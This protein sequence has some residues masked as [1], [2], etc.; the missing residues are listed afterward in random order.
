M[1]SGVLPPLFLH[2]LLLMRRTATYALEGIH[3]FFFFLLLGDAAARR[4]ARR[5][6]RQASP[7]LS[8]C[9]RLVPSFAP[10]PWRDYTCIAI[11]FHFSLHG[12]CGLMTLPAF[13]Y[14]YAPPARLGRGHCRVPSILSYLVVGMAGGGL[15]HLVAQCSGWLAPTCSILAVRRH[16][17]C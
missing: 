13:F 2:S 10:L 15:W 8:V 12:C 3:F 4:L 6:G 16:R 9:V 1:R 7:H 11:L 14:H 5:R 17:L